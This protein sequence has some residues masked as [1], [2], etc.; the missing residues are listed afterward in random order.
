MKDYF[1]PGAGLSLEPARRGLGSGVREAG[2]RAVPPAA[3]GAGG[4]RSA[5]P[6]AHA[7]D[8]CRWESGAPPR[9]PAMVAKQRIRMANEKH[10]KNIT[11][12][13]NV[14][15]T[16]RP[17][18]EKYPVGPWLLALFVFVVCGS[19]ARAPGS[20]PPGRGSDQ[21]PQGSRGKTDS[22][23][24]SLV[25]PLCEGEDSWPRDPEGGSGVS[26]QLP[27]GQAEG[28]VVSQ[29]SGRHF[30]RRGWSLF[31]VSRRN[32][33]HASAWG[34][35]GLAPTTRWASV[36]RVLSTALALRVHVLVESRDPERH[37]VPRSQGCG[38]HP[39]FSHRRVKPGPGLAA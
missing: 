8:P 19:V 5:L 1:R 14:A 24:A 29:S 21:G 22:V 10:S 15:K 38:R 35:A 32:S 12:R 39:G 30:R 20:R 27:P 17:Q 6:G 7:G 33:S 37:A 36:S 16:L 13:G 28:G 23:T 26:P 11:Q 34:G 2:G 18:E 3:P 9:A 25:A 31:S 4:T